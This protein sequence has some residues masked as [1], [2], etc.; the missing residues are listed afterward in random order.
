L[1]NILQDNF[2][3]SFVTVTIGRA[4]LY[5]RIVEKYTPFYNAA[6]GIKPIE[7]TYSVDE[8]RKNHEKAYMPWTTRDDD[9]L[10]RLKKSGKT[11]DELA[12]LFGRKKGAITS[13]LA[14]IEFSKSAKY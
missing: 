10:W 11:I 3:L 5:E 14:K 9:E 13:R 4:E 12:L 7:K 8:I 1:D 2:E 6:S